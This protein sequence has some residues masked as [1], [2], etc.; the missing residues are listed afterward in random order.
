MN[1]I[2]KR[3]EYINEVYNPMLEEKHYE[4][5]KAINE[6][7]LRTLFGM[8]KNMFKKDWDTINDNGNP[9]IV[10][11]YKEMDDKL[12]GFTTMKLSKKG[13]C[14][15]VRQALVDFACDWYDYKKNKAKESESDLKP[16]KSMKFKNDTLK[17]NIDA[18]QQKINDIV[19][20]DEQMKKWADIL[21]RDM[22]TV[23]NKSILA[24]DQIK[25][26]ETKKNLEKEV[27]EDSKKSESE[28]KAMEEWQ[29]G[30]LE[31]IEKERETLI[32]NVDATPE[33]GKDFGDKEISKLLGGLK[34]DSK[35]NLIDSFKN[36]GVLGFKKIYASSN[37]S[38]DIKISDRS[39]NILNAFYTQLK[40]DS[41]QFKE[42]PAQS[43]QAMC[44]AMNAFTKMCGTKDLNLEKNSNDLKVELMTRCA[45]ISDGV[46][47]YNLPLNG[48]EGDDAGNYFTDAIK[49]LSNVQDEYKDIKFDDRFKENAKA[50]YEKI[51]EK[52]KK[53]EDD[54]KE[55]RKKDMERINKKES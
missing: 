45:V 46:I 6:G 51:K 2:L 27:E 28:N 12:T 7:L 4:E 11:A 19:K 39:Y 23:I 32:T 10:Q 3:D 37:G 48:K 8:V 38:T 14:N 1:K 17:E 31:Q 5:L 24:D 50:I 53:L 47:S 42:T 29:R 35:E 15:Q 52:A 21:M 13:E 41:A 33:K 18:C 49:K 54:F 20:D 44:I 36:D 30:Q 9:S 26:E 40:K 55:K 25:D 43:V 16:A 22:K 34:F